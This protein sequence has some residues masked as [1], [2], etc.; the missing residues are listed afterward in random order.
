MMNRVRSFSQGRERS[1]ERER[2]GEREGSIGMDQE[3]IPKTLGELQMR[4]E[5]ERLRKE[6]DEKRRG[7]NEKFKAELVAELANVIRKP[8][9]NPPTLSPSPCVVMDDGKQDPNEFQKLKKMFQEMPT[10]TGANPREYLV[11]FNNVCESNFRNGITLAACDAKHILASKLS[12][13]IASQYPTISEMSFYE[14]FDSLISRYDSSETSAMA[15]DKLLEIHKRVKS[16]QELVK[17]ALRLFGLLRLSKIENFRIFLLAMRA[18]SPNHLKDKLSSITDDPPNIERVIREMKP[19]Q[20]EINRLLENRNQKK[21]RKVELDENIEGEVRGKLDENNNR[22]KHDESN[23]YQRRNDFQNDNSNKFERNPNRESI[24][25]ENRRCRRCGLQGHF[26]KQCRTFMCNMCGSR[27]HQ[28]VL[29]KVYPHQEPIVGECEWC[30][31]NRGI[32][33]RHS[34]KDCKKDEFLKN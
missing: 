13:D 2:E 21:Y 1:R 16:Y 5:I 25:Y 6:F 33:C 32:A 17:E 31:E 12:L 26:Y 14:L 23:P 22:I 24:A 19:Y 10:F 30:R 28:S 20:N 27:R 8:D 29:C 15:L 18:C 9:L 34:L 3:E 11:Q 7:D 4:I